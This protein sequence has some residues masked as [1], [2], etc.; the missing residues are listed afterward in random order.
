MLVKKIQNGMLACF[1][2]HTIRYFVSEFNII[3]K[4]DACVRMWHAC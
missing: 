1:F 3:L 2:L 4:I